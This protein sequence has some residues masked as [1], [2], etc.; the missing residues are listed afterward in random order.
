MKKNQI[1]L[2][3]STFLYGI[4]IFLMVTTLCLIANHA[5]AQS[6]KKITING[7]TVQHTP[8]TQKSSLMCVREENRTID[9]TCN[10]LNNSQTQNWGATDIPLHRGMYANYGAPDFYNEMGGNCRLSARAV[11]NLI[12]AQSEDELSPRGLSAL[13]F[14]WGQ[15]LDHDIDLTPEGHGEYVPVL[16]P[17]DEPLFTAP[18]PFFRSEP[19]TGTGETSNRQQQNIITSWIDGSQIYG[20]DQARADWLRT[21]QGGKLKT[22]SGNLLPYNTLNGE[23]DGSIDP[24]APS[25]AGDGSGTTV[26]F[27]A[28]DVRANEQPGLTALHTLFV[29]EHN[30]ICDQLVAQ[31][32]T[33]DEEIYQQA[34]KMVGGILQAITYH[35]FLPTLGVSVNNYNG[36]RANVQPDIS[37]LFAT[38]AYRLGHTMV[39]NNIPLLAGN[40]TTVDDGSLALL[41][42]FFNPSVIA[43]YDIAPIL[44]GLAS[45]TQQKV[46]TKIVD[47]LR[48]FL[49]PAPGSDELFG[50]DLASLNLQ[51]G[52]DHGLPD[53]NS[54]RAHYT[55]IAAD[56]FTD[57]TSD[58]ALQ[59]NLEKAYGSVYNMDVWIGMLA[60]DPLP[61]SSIGITLNAVL[62]DQ[63]ER[64]RNADFY[65]FQNDPAFS[66]QQRNQ[67]ENT[68]LADVIN[69]NTAIQ[70]ANDNVFFAESCSVANDDDDD[71]NDGNGNNGDGGNNGNGDGG[72]NNGGGNGGN[73]NGN[74]GNNGG[75]N[76]NNGGGNN[77]GGNGNN[78]GNNGGGNG[79]N[80]G[81][82]GG[83]N[84]GGGIIDEDAVSNLLIFPNPTADVVQLNITLS[85]PAENVL[86]AVQNMEG[87]Q[88]YSKKM[89]AVSK[90]FFYDLDLSA[91]PTGMYLIQIQ[92]GTE[93]LS[94]RLAV[95]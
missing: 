24:T 6:T 64:L 34:R 77:G 71:D 45:Q 9:G 40:C 93:V 17:S 47:N 3:E 37:N 2:H 60:E 31:G 81:G 39:T 36:Y 78:G 38:A 65:Y 85:E 29:R 46:D 22:S 62:A 83:G 91:F 48:N 28:G 52:R 56:D 53:Y 95:K 41:E 13:V 19:Y 59:A 20:S 1:V 25:M 27:V 86:I 16:L 32:A 7:K 44:Q 26:V 58:P 43:E 5:T 94:E 23:V 4:M 54:V 69:R 92:T 12:C 11:S 50:L 89:T 73:N 15:F 63:F 49:F 14:T 79:G 61:N 88:V 72:N 33:D 67:I 35:G 80:G 10:N 68:T 21:F 30:R 87:K 51:R 66:P 74:G 55:G 84:G 76:G 57:I 18:I 70:T 82:Q 90:Q 8:R 42:G 75:G